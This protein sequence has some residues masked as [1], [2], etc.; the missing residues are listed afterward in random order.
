MSTLFISPARSRQVI[1]AIV[2]FALV[3]VFV[4]RTSDAAFTAETTNP[5]NLFRTAAIG[6]ETEEETPLFGEG[7]DGSPASIVPAVDLIPGQ[8]IDGCLNVA[9]EGPDGIDLDEVT[10][11]VAIGEDPNELAQALTVTVDLLEGSCGSDVQGEVTD[12][13]LLALDGNVVD[14]G[15][16]PDGDE[17]RGFNF[18]VTVDDGLDEDSMGDTV[19]GVNLIWSVSTTS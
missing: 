19:T 16:A 6:L 8:Q 12:G 11:D 18:T 15:W 5:D 10:F 14:T 9:Y 13:S 1:A 2:A 7:P 3:S 4:I 17:T